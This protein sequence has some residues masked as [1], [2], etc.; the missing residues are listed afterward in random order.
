M[1]GNLNWKELLK[2][3]SARVEWKEGGG[4]ADDMART[5]CA[6]ANDFQMVG[7]GI[8]ICGIEESKDETPFSK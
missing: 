8:L 5:L 6:S 1:D 2:K 4:Y 3:E 7:G